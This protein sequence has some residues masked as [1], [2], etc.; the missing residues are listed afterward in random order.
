MRIPLSILDMPKR[1]LGEAIE[2]LKF[3]GEICIKAD[4][5]RKDSI[6]VVLTKREEGEKS[7][8]ENHIAVA[9]PELN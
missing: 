6:W 9:Q 8:I 5:R 2:G 4:K 1:L 3:S 7:S